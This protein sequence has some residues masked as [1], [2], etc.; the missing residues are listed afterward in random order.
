MRRTTLLALACGLA[1]AGL[2]ALGAL[3]IGR[4]TT[5][6][7]AV[8]RDT[9]DAQLVAA[10][11]QNFA[12]EHEDVRLKVVH[13]NDAAASAVALEADSADLAVVRS[14]I[15]L[16]LNGQTLALL[17]RNAAIILATSRSKVAE[18]GDLRGK[19]VGVV[20]GPPTGAGNVRLLEAI[21]AQNEIAA[22][23]VVIKDLTR[24]QVFDALSTGAVAAV[25]T[26]G[27]L[28]TQAVRDVVGAATLASGGD[29]VFIPVSEAKAMAQHAPVFEAIEIVRGSFGGSPPKPAETFETLGVSVRLMAASTMRDALAGQLTRQLF[30][31]RP[32]IAQAAP[33]ANQIEAP[34]TV[35]GAAMPVHPG[36]AA[37]L[38]D[39]EQ[40]F[41]ERYTD[42]IYIGAMIVSVL[43]SAAAALASR[44]GSKKSSDKNGGES[45]QLLRRLLE[46][47]RAARVADSLAILDALEREADDILM[48]GVVARSTHALD[49][50]TMSALTLTLDQ[51][52]LAIKDRRAYF[53]VSPRLVQV[54]GR[55]GRGV[56]VPP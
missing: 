14:D 1:A 42:A 44:M 47:L 48:S 49:A 28:N 27:A 54:D 17:H 40:T 10:I 2:I 5:L 16:P 6:R 3:W 50:Q 11:A 46:V 8:V 43:G 33:L 24:E 31:N 19:T 35:R 22:R 39:E 12:K 25:V 52:R 26:V 18:I 51:A 21:L 29:P 38:D 45:D 9:E 13:V 7:I 34:S 32:S 56:P 23:D 37:Y 36:A 4:P 53:T 20:R 30:A 15:R 55:Q 41:F